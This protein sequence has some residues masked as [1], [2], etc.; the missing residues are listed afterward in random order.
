[1]YLATVNNKNLLDNFPKDEGHNALAQCIRK[2]AKNNC[3]EAH[4]IWYDHTQ[5]NNRGA[6]T[7]PTIPN[8]FYGNTDDVAFETIK[9]GGQ[10][11]YKGTC[12]YASCHSPY[13]IKDNRSWFILRGDQGTLSEQIQRHVAPR[14]ST[15][16]RCNVGMVQWKGL[17]FEDKNNPWM[18]KFNHNGGTSTKNEEFY[19]LPQTLTMEDEKGVEHIFKLQTAILYVNDNHYTSLQNYKGKWLHYDGMGEMRGNTFPRRFRAPMPSD[20]DPKGPNKTLLSS[21]VYIRQFK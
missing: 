1:M 15:C 20:T 7:N 6:L 8:D 5:K 4:Q 9:H 10:F 11:V 19:N 18:I 21:I 3:A 16:N 13:H 2:V 12:D 14:Q 17:G